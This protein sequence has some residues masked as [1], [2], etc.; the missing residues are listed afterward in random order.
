M[1]DRIAIACAILGFALWFTVHVTVAFGLA[2]RESVARGLLAF[3]AFPLAPIW[4]WKERMHVRFAL[5][6][7]FAAIYICGFVLSSRGA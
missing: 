3:V 7:V 6:M 2:R 4:A 5:W 1:S